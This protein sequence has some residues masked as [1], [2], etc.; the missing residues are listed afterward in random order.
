MSLAINLVDKLAITAITTHCGHWTKP[1]MQGFPV[2][3]L[4]EMRNKQRNE[5][6][7]AGENK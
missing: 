6:E 5:G 1:L 7:S 2:R 3:L 4:P